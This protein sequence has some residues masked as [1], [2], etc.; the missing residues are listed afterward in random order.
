MEINSLASL[1]TSM[2]NNATDQ[3]VSIAVLKKTLDTQAAGALA[4]L[5]AIPDAPTQ[6]LPEHLGQNVNTTA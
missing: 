2:A 6:N 1:A 3:A 4:L 5:Q